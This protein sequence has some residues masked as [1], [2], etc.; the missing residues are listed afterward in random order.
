[1]IE[2]SGHLPTIN[3]E[4]VDWPASALN[5]ARLRVKWGA[6]FDW[7]GLSQRRGGTE[8]IGWPGLSASR[9]PGGEFVLMRGVIRL[10]TA[11]DC[12]CL[13]S[14]NGVPVFQCKCPTEFGQGRNQVAPSVPGLREALRPGHP[15]REMASHFGPSEVSPQTIAPKSFA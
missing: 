13:V 8:G 3:N 4:C 10:V 7:I 2:H 11:G 6:S 1:M 14:G 15:F 12:S 9:R 5:R